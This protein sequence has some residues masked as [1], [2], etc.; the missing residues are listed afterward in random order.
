MVELAQATA[1][2]TDGREAL[3]VR[4]RQKLPCI[5]AQYF[6]MTVTEPAQQPVSSHTSQYDAILLG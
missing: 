5:L 1:K 6:R 3:N 2:P 4:H